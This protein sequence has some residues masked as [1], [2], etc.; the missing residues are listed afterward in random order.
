MSAQD[1]PV[2]D[3]TLN[4]QPAQAAPGETLWQVAQRVGVDIP[5][6]CHKPG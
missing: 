6:L 5:H 3:F 1:L 2:I 4:G